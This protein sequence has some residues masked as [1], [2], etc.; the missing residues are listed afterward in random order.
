M[1]AGHYCRFECGIPD[2]KM[3]SLNFT[4]GVW[5]WP[6]GLSHYVDV[7]CVRLPSEFLNHLE[8]RRFEYPSQVTHETFLTQENNERFKKSSEQYQ[9]VMAKMSKRGK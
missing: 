7:H 6:E 9:C 3:G 2:S 1:P 8:L 4:D 5:A